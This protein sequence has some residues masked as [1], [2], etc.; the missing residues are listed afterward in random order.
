M[1]TAADPMSFARPASTWRS[2]PMRSTVASIALFNSSTTS[3]S[4]IGATSSA[5][6]TPVCP[7]Q[8]PRGMTTT[9]RASSWRNAASLRYAPTSPSQLATAARKMRST[10]RGFGRSPAVSRITG[11]CWAGA[12][13]TGFAAA[14]LASTSGP[15]AWRRARHL[16]AGPAWYAERRAR[17]R[18]PLRPRAGYAPWHR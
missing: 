11:L 2:S 8:R 14:V 7:S 5:R 18:V 13:S 1:R 17:A 6:S 10:P 15:V 3:T 4:S 16:N 9:A 12:G